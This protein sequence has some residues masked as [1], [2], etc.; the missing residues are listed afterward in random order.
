MRLSK[1]RDGCV[2]AILRRNSVLQNQV[3]NYLLNAYPAY[4][5]MEPLVIQVWIF[6]VSTVYVNMRMGP[7]IIR[8]RR[9]VV[10]IPEYIG[11]FPILSEKAVR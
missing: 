9:S 1:K 11:V 7:L 2:L 10:F 8:V 3:G 5:N 4:G 6:R